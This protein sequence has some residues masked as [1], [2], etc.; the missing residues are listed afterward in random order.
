MQLINY[1]VGMNAGNIN[2]LNSLLMIGLSFWSYLDTEKGILTLPILL[3]MMLM[4]QSQGVRAESVSLSKVCTV[5]TVIASLSVAYIIWY[6]YEKRNLEVIIKVSIVLVSN[7]FALYMFS[8][9]FRQKKAR[10][11]LILQRQQDK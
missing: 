9:F 11:K 8:R 6:F 7:I 1:V 2:L 4:V 3:G 10:R 5:I